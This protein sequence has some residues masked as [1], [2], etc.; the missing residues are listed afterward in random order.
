MSVR[1]TDNVIVN[2]MAKLHI[3]GN[4]IPQIWYKTILR[5]NGKPHLLAI[6][7]LAD[8]VYWYRPTEIRNP[9]TGETIG[10]KQKFRGEYLQRSYSYFEDAFG[11][12]KKSI[13]RALQTLEKIGVIS[14]IVQD[15]VQVGQKAYGNVLYIKLNISGLSAVTYPD[16]APE[17]AD[18][19]A[20]IKEDNP[21]PENHADPMDKA[22]HTYGRDCPD[23]V[24]KAVHTYGRDCPD[25]VD[26][27]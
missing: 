3:S 15:V 4:V 17:A 20:F 25:P 19:V 16:A 26:K 27:A 14:R 1:M 8:I 7:I 21:K 12:S 10:W 2:E 9:D 6:T 23:P 11:E 13:Q 24:D 5:D 22:V 18:S